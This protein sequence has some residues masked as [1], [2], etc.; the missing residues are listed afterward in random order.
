MSIHAQLSPEAVERLRAQSRNTTLSAIAI[1][2]LALVFIGVLLALWLLPIFTTGSEPTL[3]IVRTVRAEPITTQAPK[4]P[5]S[6]ARPSAPSRTQAPVIA[7]TP[8][9]INIPTPDIPIT[10]PSMNYGSGEDFGDG[11]IGGGD[12]NSNKGQFTGIQG[13]TFGSRCDLKERLRRLAENGGNDACEAAVVKGLRWLKQTQ[14]EDGSW[15]STNREAM[16]GLA[17]LAF[18]GHCETPLSEEFGNAVT[19]AIAYLIDSSMKNKG[20]LTGNLPAISGCYEHAIGTYALAEAYT[21]CSKLGV[22]GIPNLRECVEKAVNIIIAGQHPSGGWDY[23]YDVGATRGGDVS[24]SGWQIQ[25]LKAANHTGIEFREMRK[26]TTKALGYLSDCQAS[27]GAF[28]YTARKEPNGARF[29]LTGVGVL[30]FQMWDK[31][32]AREVRRGIDFIAKDSGISWGNGDKGHGDLY[33]AY[34][35][36]Q[37]MMNQG[38]NDWLEYNKTFRDSLLNNQAPNGTW[39]ATKDGHHGLGGA[40]G[41][42]EHYRTTLCILM[43]EVYYRFLPGT[44][45]AP[46]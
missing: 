6:Q 23:R 26:V 29:A 31:P 22:V 7:S 37:A 12:G 2:L 11:G 18:L 34:Y 9:Q 1:S 3:D 27:N 10:L 41:W 45:G 19:R 28:G 16:T 43:L 42:N 20:Y 24:V 32:R 25:A 5:M 44:G 33:S 39:P 40:G 30:A 36:S 46:K 13:S 8:A 35:D 38:G 15:T 4:V 17:L 14:N 21:L